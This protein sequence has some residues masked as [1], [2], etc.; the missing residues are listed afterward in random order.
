MNNVLSFINCAT[1][2]GL[3]YYKFGGFVNNTKYPIL[4]KLRHS[5]I[6]CL[7]S[8]VISPLLTSYFCE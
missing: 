5:I 2:I 8:L 6:I 4:I 7:P 1:F 3:I